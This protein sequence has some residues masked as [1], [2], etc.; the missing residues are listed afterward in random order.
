MNPNHYC[1]LGPVCAIQE[2]RYDFSFLKVS[3]YLNLTTRNGLRQKALNGSIHLHLQSMCWFSMYCYH[4]RETPVPVC[5]PK[6]DGVDIWMG[7]HLD[8]ILCAVLLGKSGW[9][10]GHQS[11]L[12]PLLQCCMWIEFQSIST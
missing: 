10:S 12:P 5:S 8:K 4:Q 7:D 1:I 2:C 9:R 3:F 11:R 6:L